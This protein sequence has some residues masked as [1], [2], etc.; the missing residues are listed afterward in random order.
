MARMMRS[1]SP[2]AARYV[3]TLENMKSPS[4]WVQDGRAGAHHA[5]LPTLRPRLRRSNQGTR[6]PAG[7]LVEAGG[8]ASAQRRFHAAQHALD[9]R[10]L[11]LVEPALQGSVVDGDRLATELG[12]LLQAPAQVA[13]LGPRLELRDGGLERGAQLQRRVA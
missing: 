3:R 12:E 9:G 1:T 11:V 6:P 8:R 7:Q 13:A 5:V 4:D 2:G 10:R